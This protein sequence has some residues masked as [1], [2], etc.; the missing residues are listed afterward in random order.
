MS[1]GLGLPGSAAKHR[2]STS[3]GVLR[4]VD[5]GAVFDSLPFKAA[6]VEAGVE[7]MGRRVSRT[8][9]VAA[10]EHLRRVGAGELVV[11]TAATVLT[12]SEASECLVARLYAAQIAGLAVRLDRTFALPREMLVAADRH[13]LPV[14]T[15]PEDAAL[16]DVTAAFLD[17][18]L[19]A[20]RQRHE[21][22]LDMH[23]RFTRIVLAGGGATDI[24]A[25]LHDVLGYPVAVVDTDGRATVTVPSDGAV[26]LHLADASTIRQP[27]RAGEHDYGEIVALTD[28]AAVD[29]D[30]LIAVERAAMAVAVRLARAS[31]VAKAEQRFAAISL[32]ELIAGHGD[33]AAGVTER[34]I[35]FGW[36]LT[37]PRAVLLASIDPPAD[38]G[39][40]A[41]A[42]NTIAAAARATLGPDAIIWP[43]S[44]TIAALLAP[45]TDDP[46]ERRRVA[47]RL[48]HELDQRLRSVT[49]SI[50]VGRRVDTPSLLPRSFDE[51]SR[52]VDVGRWAKGRH[53]TE[54]FDELGLERLLSA[55]PRDDLAEFVQQAIG[56]LA[57]HDRTHHT[58]LIETLSVWLETRNMAEAARRIHVHYNTLKNRLD[59]V[60]ALIGPV[61]T[62][63]ARAL[64]CEV[65]IHVDRHYDM[66]R[67]DHPDCGL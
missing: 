41:A 25:T 9:L 38:C 26:V 18:L 46:A 8:R 60:E 4:S 39:I 65:A 13:S 17:A 16:A 57:R 52:A 58:D 31:A 24:A 27:I 29:E 40:P 6:A 43:R 47:E 64:E 7:G 51:A 67:A 42:L 33:G 37:R 28:G 53:V 63:A 2:S 61:V 45:D 3:D 10:P 36:D 19:E 59:R 1:R 20:Q 5:I 23:Q 49:V 22:V 54:V 11:T 62:D 30:G 14:I 50:G 48:R 35:S 34:A 12:A 32:E 56:P 44:T 15:L 55:T 21:H 66:S